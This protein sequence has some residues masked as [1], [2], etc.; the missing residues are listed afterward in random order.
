ME[1]RKATIN[2]VNRCETNK[3]REVGMMFD[4]SRIRSEIHSKL[5]KN[6]SS[7]YFLICIHNSF[8]YPFEKNI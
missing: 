5:N 4:A 6:L 1:L 8:V 7:Q 3:K 2:N